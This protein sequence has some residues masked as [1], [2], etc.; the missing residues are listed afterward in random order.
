MTALRLIFILITLFFFSCTRDISSHIT[1]PDGK[2]LLEFSL[3]QG[4]P[5]FT[6]SFDGKKI[7]RPSALGFSLKNGT[8]LSGN[9]RVVSAESK[10]VDT[11]WVPVWGTDNKIRDQYNALE[12]HLYSEQNALKLSLIFRAY[13]DG[14]AFRYI[15]PRQKE[16]D[17]FE[18]ISERTAFTFNEDLT[19]WWIPQDFESYESYFN[20]KITLEM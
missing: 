2:I 9:F 12:L 1:S 19:S 11:S 16:L 5:R 10:T 8:D 6:V 3:E 7:I 15:F 20:S 13:N 17:E 18:I 4:N 14:I